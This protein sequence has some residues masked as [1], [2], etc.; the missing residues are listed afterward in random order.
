MEFLSH[1]GSFSFIK[2]VPV[3]V[4]SEFPCFIPSLCLSPGHLQR[5]PKLKFSAY[6]HN[7]STPHPSKWMLTT[8]VVF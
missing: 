4:T 5:N 7:A 2:S 6:K 8:A 3:L 1:I